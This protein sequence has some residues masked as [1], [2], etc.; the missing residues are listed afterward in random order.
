MMHLKL[1]VLLSMS[2]WPVLASATQ[3]SLAGNAGWTGVGILGAV[4]AWFFFYEHPSQK[5]ASEDRFN[6]MLE[7]EERRTKENNA[8]QDKLLEEFKTDLQTVVNGNRDAIKIVMDSNEGSIR[9]LIA[10]HQKEVDGITSRFVESVCRA[11]RGG[12]V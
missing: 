7:C 3:D 1:S 11:D 10:R 5:K 8:R 9:D 2:L 6:K 4:L 12:Q